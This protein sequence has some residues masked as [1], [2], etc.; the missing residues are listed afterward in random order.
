[1]KKIK[2]MFFATITLMIVAACGNGKMQDVV[3]PVSP[4]AD[5]T[6][7]M[8]SFV[9][10]RYQGTNPDVNFEINENGEVSD[11]SIHI[12]FST[13]TSSSYDCTVF[14]DWPSRNTYDLTVHPDG[15]FLYED[16]ENSWV[17]V[18][19]QIRGDIAYGS[20]MITA[21]G[22]DGSDYHFEEPLKGEWNAR[23]AT[24]PPVSPTV[25]PPPPLEQGLYKGS[26]PD[27]SFVIAENGEMEKFHI[28]ISTSEGQ[29]DLSQ[30]GRWVL[31]R[32]GYFSA[33]DGN[34]SVNGTVESGHA[35][36]SYICESSAGIGIAAT[37]Q[38]SAD[39]AAKPVSAE[40]QMVAQ[41]LPLQIFETSN[42]SLICMGG[43]THYDHLYSYG[44]NWV[45]AGTFDCATPWGVVEV[46][47]GYFNTATGEVDIPDHGGFSHDDDSPVGPI[48]EYSLVFNA[49]GYNLAAHGT[50]PFD[51]VV[52]KIKLGDKDSAMTKDIYE[53]IQSIFT[54][55][56]DLLETFISAGQFPKGKALP[57]LNV[58]ECMTQFVYQESD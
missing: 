5:V 41:T 31:D 26:V 32:K 28:S 9:T 6:P 16:Q 7:T 8:F 20:Y 4:A 18:S 58:E 2:L 15:S 44:D 21:S 19:G 56:P 13:S 53:P 52:L 36:G 42:Y 10:G 23:W 40:E 45:S 3:S 14:T 57:A 39:L 55:E 37:G 50:D 38:W 25:T 54:T 35:E 17:R 11:F 43:K 46:A 27:V 24:S 33:F 48:A 30:E 51:G 29:C 34:S 22:C 47:M 1:M 12:E 49:F